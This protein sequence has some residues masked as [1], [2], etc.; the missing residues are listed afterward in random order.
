MTPFMTP[1]KGPSAPKSVV[2]VMMPGLLTPARRPCGSLRGRGAALGFQ[3][4]LQLVE[5]LDELR[6]PFALELAGDRLKIDP[7][8]L[9]G[10]ALVGGLGNVALEAQLWPP[11]APVGVDGLQRH[12]VDRIRHHQLLDVLH[13]A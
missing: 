5:G 4:L 12:G 9:E 8:A 10:L 3:P 2:R 1:T 6:H 13:R 7:E 11:D